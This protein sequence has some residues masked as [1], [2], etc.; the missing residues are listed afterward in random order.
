MSARFQSK[1]GESRLVIELASATNRDEQ[2]S[3]STESARSGRIVVPGS[4]QPRS[5]D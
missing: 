2:S 1:K 4:D 5:R 3:F